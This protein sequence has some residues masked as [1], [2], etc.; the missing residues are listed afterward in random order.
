M[1]RAKQELPVIPTEILQAIVLDVDSPQD[2]LSVRAAN[3]TLNDLATPRAFECLTVKDT[4]ESSLSF[5]N[6][7][8]SDGEVKPHVKNVIFRDQYLDDGEDG[9]ELSTELMPFSPYSNDIEVRE[10]IIAALSNLGSLPKLESIHLHFN[11]TWNEETSLDMEDP[12]EGLQFQLEVLQ[13]LANISS[14]LGPR[15][16]SLEI[17]NLIAFPKEVLVSAPF[18]TLFHHLEHLQMSVI[19]D[20]DSEGAVYEDPI[21]DFWGTTI[22]TILRAASTSGSLKDLTLMSDQD[23]SGM[24]LPIFPAGL[25]YP[26]LDTLFL[27]NILFNAYSGVEDFIVRHGKSLKSLS[28]DTCQMT[29]EDDAETRDLNWAQVW[30]RWSEVLTE[31]THLGV[32][33]DRQDKDGR[34]LSYA[35]NNVGYGWIPL[36]DE[37]G[38]AEEEDGPAL[39]E[40]RAK[41]KARKTMVKTDHD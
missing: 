35:Y 28:L 20:K 1:V 14:T 41:V 10:R 23:I 29:V 17:N 25:Q 36:F 16:R 30:R 19:S 33:F 7:L 5:F 2:L 6:L 37:L 38:P 12:S 34:I 3:R 21:Q 13:T 27:R 22:P 4:E 9:T 15:L 11:R 32:R 31:L 24:G 8:Q 40:F 18:L 26:T 39:K